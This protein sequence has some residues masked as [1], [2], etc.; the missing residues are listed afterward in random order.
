V[1]MASVKFTI[2]FYFISFLSFSILLL[3]VHK[4]ELTDSDI[5]FHCI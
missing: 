5:P 3:V 1:N 2:V 4:F